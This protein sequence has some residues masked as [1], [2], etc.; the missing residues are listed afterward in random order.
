M[1]AIVLYVC[2]L[3]LCVSVSVSVDIVEFLKVNL[4]LDDS[5]SRFLS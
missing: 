2:R 3:F 4:K 1:R 5:L